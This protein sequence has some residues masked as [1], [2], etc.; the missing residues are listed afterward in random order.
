MSE[1]SIG[2]IFKGGVYRPEKGGTNNSQEK[3]TNDE[4]N[5]TPEQRVARLL[6]YYK[7]Q[8]RVD[9]QAMNLFEGVNADREVAGQKPYENMQEFLKENGK[10]SRAASA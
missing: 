10:K 6:A 8:G 5:S 2:E 7:N 9:S 3:I 4:M 1:R